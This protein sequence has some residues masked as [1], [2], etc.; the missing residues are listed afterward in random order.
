[1]IAHHNTEERMPGYGQ[2]RSNQQRTKRCRREKSIQDIF[3][4]SESE[5][6]GS[7]IYDPVIG[8]IKFSVIINNMIQNKPFYKLFNTR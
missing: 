7:S 5:R 2:K 6:Y 4:S 8:L 1:M 3:E